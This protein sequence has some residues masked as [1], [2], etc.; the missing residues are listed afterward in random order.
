MMPVLLG[1]G[2]QIIV[3][4]SNIKRLEKRRHKPEKNSVIVNYNSLAYNW[5]LSVEKIRLLVVFMTVW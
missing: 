2:F 5:Y 1:F 4:L 3:F